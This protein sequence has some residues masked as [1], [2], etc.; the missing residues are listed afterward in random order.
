MITKPDAEEFSQSLEQ[1]GEGWFR[2]L[3]LGIKLEIPEALNLTRREWA[4]RIGVK[5]RNRAER[6]NIGIELAA[7]GLSNR[8]IA[9]VV[10][11]GHSTINRDLSGPNGPSSEADE[12]SGAGVAGDQMVHHK[13]KLADG[14][15]G[16]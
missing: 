15:S 12:E 6:I 5:V 2:Q 11:V 13:C 3:A 14:A 7:E 1:I 10:G 4:D 9:D 8:E 16:V